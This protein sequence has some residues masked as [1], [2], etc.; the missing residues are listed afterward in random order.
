ME[1]ESAPKPWKLWFRL[2][3]NFPE[4]NNNIRSHYT[5]WIM[6]TQPYPARMLSG[7]PQSTLDETKWSRIPVQ[8][9]RLMFY[10]YTLR[11]KWSYPSKTWP[12]RR[13]VGSRQSFGHSHLIVDCGEWSASRYGRATLEKNNLIGL[14]KCSWN[15]LSRK[16]YIPHR[17]PKICFI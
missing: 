14:E 3:S 17:A 4:D 11:I 5:N 9:L 2:R 16:Q 1:A 13:M 15:R 10:W 8:H 7:R 12:W 6:P